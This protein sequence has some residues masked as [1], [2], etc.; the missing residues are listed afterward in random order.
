[1]RLYEKV[2]VEVNSLTEHLEHF[3]LLSKETITASFPRGHPE[4][5]LRVESSGATCLFSL[6][7]PGIPSGSDN[8]DGAYLFWFCPLVEVSEALN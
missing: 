6:C 7:G 3:S 4:Q 1:M 8:K 2:L 5:Q